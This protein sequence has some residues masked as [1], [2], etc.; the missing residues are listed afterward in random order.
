MHNEAVTAP[1]LVEALDRVLDRPYE[2]V[3]V[4]DGSTDA[5]NQVLHDLARQDARVVPV[6]LSRN[7]GKEG[8]LSA[9]LEIAR[10]DAVILMDADLQHPPEVIPSLLDKWDE[11]FDVVNAVKADRGR[12][13][14]AYRACAA[15][16]YRLMGSSMRE[17]MDGQSD[18]KLLDRQVVDAVLA[19]EERNR[20][21]RGLV[22]WLGFRVAEVPFTVAE[23]AGGTTSW[24]LMGLVRY[25]V[26]SLIAFSSAPLLSIAWVGFLTM[27]AAALLALQTFYN[28]WTGAALDGFTT[29][30]LAVLIMGGAILLCQGVISLYLAVI[31]DELKGRSLFVLRKDASS[32]TSQQKSAVVEMP[33][34]RERPA[35]Q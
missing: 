22:A 33:K 11:G 24:G 25:S 9:G 18:F 14:L 12:E 29:V 32:Q 20:F 4:D 35:G 17:R 10:G 7:F 5:T 16:F 8:A 27:G 31:Y 15:M 23:R 28:W 19:C 13:S 2:V 26:K 1:K 6:T 30:I 3:C 21:F 34:P